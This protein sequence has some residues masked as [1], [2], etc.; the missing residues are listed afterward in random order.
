MVMP[1]GTPPIE[2]GLGLP[3]HR[4]AAPPL[5]GYTVPSGWGSPPKLR[6]PGTVIAAAVLAYILGGLGILAPVL[7]ELGLVMIA[8]VPGLLISVLYVA[9]GLWLQL[10][11]N[12]AFLLWLVIADL[13]LEAAGLVL[14]VTRLVGGSATKGGDGLLSLILPI[15][16]LALL[17]HRNTTE[18]VEARRGG[19][20]QPMS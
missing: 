20:G 5:T 4:P 13:A 12:R 1:Q 17:R 18:W 19:P 8:W 9:A 6:A 7:V 2:P 3:D 11:A 15:I 10:R 14:T 16:V